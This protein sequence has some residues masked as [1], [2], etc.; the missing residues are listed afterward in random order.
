VF[1]G[2]ANAGGE[3][4]HIGGAIAGF[5]FIR[6]PHHLHGMFDFMGQF[7]PTSRTAKARAAVRRSGAQHTE[8]DR[9]LGKIRQSG[10]HSLTDDEKRTL[11]EASRR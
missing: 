3:A 6:N 4:A 7:D 10:L 9:I 11:R 5:Y 8:I 1:F 2:G